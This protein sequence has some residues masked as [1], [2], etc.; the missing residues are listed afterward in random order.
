MHPRE[1][2]RASL[3]NSLYLQSKLGGL[4]DMVVMDDCYHIVTVDRQRDLVVDRTVSFTSWL[5]RKSD[6][7]EV[8]NEDG[9]AVQK[10]GA[11]G[12]RV[13]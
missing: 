8:A 9:D 6:R 3:K 13:A 11:T 2:D 1:D 5:D 7:R 10:S 4:V 12:R